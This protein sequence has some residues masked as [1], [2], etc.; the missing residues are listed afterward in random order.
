MAGLI[1]VCPEPRTLSPTRLS[2]NAGFMWE[3]AAFAMVTTLALT[4]RLARGQRG[5]DWQNLTLLLAA[6]TTMSTTGFLGLAVAL[7]YWAFAGLQ[8][9]R[10][11]ATLLLPALTA[12]LL[13][14]DIILPKITAEFQTGYAENMR[15]SLSR[16]ASFLRDMAV[17][18]Q[19]PLLGT[20]LFADPGYD[21]HNG[22]SDYLRRYGLLWA[23]ASL[24]LL[25]G[26]LRCVATPLGTLAFLAVTLLFAWSEK[27]FELPLFYMLQFAIFLPRPTPGVSHASNH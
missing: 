3:P 23:L 19:Q 6:L 24:G 15:W 1:A 16:Y 8:N 27:F 12:A 14:L 2:Q 5:A 20:G 22:L 17:F 11:A 13:G 7:S 21:S 9:K 26:S 18:Q 10:L 4:L 25:A